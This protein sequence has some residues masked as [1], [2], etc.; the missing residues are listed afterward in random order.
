MKIR[1]KGHMTQSSV[2]IKALVTFCLKQNL[3]QIGRVLLMQKIS[4]NLK[5]S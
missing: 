4:R 3:R 5:G 1:M 2:I